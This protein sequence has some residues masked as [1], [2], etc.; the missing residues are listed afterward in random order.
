MRRDAPRCEARWTLAL[1][2]NTDGSLSGQAI[3][4]DDATPVSICAVAG[5]S[6]HSVRRKRGRLV[7]NNPILGKNCLEAMSSG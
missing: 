3:F 6:R 7:F 5:R 2:L 4:G 1:D